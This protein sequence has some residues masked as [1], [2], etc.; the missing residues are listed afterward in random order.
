MI[1]KIRE[2]T[3]MKNINKM[4]LKQAFID[5]I[6]VMMGYLVLGAGFGMILTTKG[7]SIIWSIAMG[8]VI[9]AGSMQYIAITLITSG[10]SL[11][12]TIITTFMVNAR[13]IFYGISMIDQYKDAGKWKP[14]IIFALTDETY[15]LLCNHKIKGQ[16]NE[17]VY[18]F[19][20]SALNHI[21]WIV[22]C[23]LGSSL[24]MVLTIDTTGIDFTLTALFITIFVEQWLQTNQHIHAIVGII[25]TASCLFFFGP[26]RFLIPSMILI[27]LILLGL[28]GK[29]SGVVE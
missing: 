28:K 26:E 15:S 13:H 5:T 4:I 11:L 24:A 12:T 9:Y 17:Y 21:Y 6:P 25:S 19:V 1:E 22:G 10:A 23:G 16:P 8:I 27:T 14:Y 2:I 20:V 3:S 18:Y 7:Y 29:E